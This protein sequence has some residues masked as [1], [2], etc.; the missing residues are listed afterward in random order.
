MAIKFAYYNGMGPYFYDTDILVIDS[1]GLFPTTYQNALVTDG[2]L[3]VE[4]QPTIEYNVA[5]FLDVITYITEVTT[6]TGTIS[7][8][9]QVVLA[10]GTFDLFLPLLAD[11]DKHIYEIKNVGT[12]L[13]SLKPNAAEP[14]KTIDEEIVQVIRPLDALT[15][16]GD[17]ANDSWW[18][19]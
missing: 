2:Q 16:Y 11:G 15:V 18:I 17:N 12:G 8:N 7:T 4:E 13:I 10:D 5:R 6:G 14:A 3:I 19:I 9:T 1:E